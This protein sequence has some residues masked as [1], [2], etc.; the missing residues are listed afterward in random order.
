MKIQNMELFKV[1]RGSEAL[2]EITK[3]T[4]SE[5]ADLRVRN[6]PRRTGQACGWSVS[7][8]P[9]QSWSGHGLRCERMYR[10]VRVLHQLGPL[11]CRIKQSEGQTQCLAQ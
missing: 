9:D 3:H 8:T 4:G 11:R 6:P 1:P 5:L 7:L 10:N 2:L